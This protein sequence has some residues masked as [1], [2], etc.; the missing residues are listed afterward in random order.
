MAD[1]KD[2]RATIWSSSQGTFGLRS[3]IAQIF[4]MPREKVRVV[5][6]DGSGSY[7]SNGA[8]DA[9][10]DAVLLSRAVSQ[11]VRLQWMRQDEH[12][13][14]PKGPAQLLEMRGALD[15]D[16]KL[17]AFESRVI[18]PT[19]PQWT[20]SLLGPRSADHAEPGSAIRSGESAG[21][22]AR[23]KSDADPSFEPAR[24]VED[25]QHLRGGELRR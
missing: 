6:L 8:Y 15:S 7:G 13:W 14:D 9:A 2:G 16:G 21:E 20:E 5:Y 12:G 10:A 11:P 18:A 3:L 1:V 19:G 25:R 24:A 23:G 22:R 4:G 17:A